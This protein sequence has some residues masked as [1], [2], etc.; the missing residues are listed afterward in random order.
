MSD[1]DRNSRVQGDAL[2]FDDVLEAIRV[3]PKGIEVR[4]QSVEVVS[5]SLALE[6][7]AV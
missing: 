7:D 2:T 6:P 1:K 4:L 3:A 5:S